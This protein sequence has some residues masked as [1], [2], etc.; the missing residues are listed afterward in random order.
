MRTGLSGVR[1]SED[2]NPLNAE[3]NPICHLLALLGAHHILHVS[4]L[5]VKSI[6]FMVIH[7][8]T[9]TNDRLAKIQRSESNQCP[10]CDQEDTLIHRLTECS[11][12]I[13]FWR[14]TRFRIAIILRTDPQHILPEWTVRPSFHFWP[15]Q[16]QGQF[17]DPHPHGVLPYSTSESSVAHRL[18]WL[19]AACPVESLSHGASA[20]K[21]WELPGDAIISDIHLLAVP[22]STVLRN[23]ASQQQTCKDTIDRHI[24][25]LTGNHLGPW[26][27]K[28]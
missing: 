25:T 14:G 28:Q 21:N 3:L 10:H 4:G 17:V 13:D 9:P 26:D 15:P 11:E 2:I 27:T 16:S 20:G 18:Y 23:I 19:H 1:V 7:D 22:L 5:R 12:G 8:L 6:W 24:A